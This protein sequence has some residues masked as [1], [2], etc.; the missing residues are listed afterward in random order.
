MET[1]QTQ[2][3]YEAFTQRLEPYAPKRKLKYLSGKFGSYIVRNVTG[4][5]I[6]GR[7]YYQD[8]QFQ[9]LYEESVNI[10]QEKASHLAKVQE[11]GITI[12]PTYFVAGTDSFNYLTLY[13]LSKEIQGSN[14]DTIR[15]LKTYNEDNLANT[16][17]N[18]IINLCA[19]YEQQFSSDDFVMDDV[20]GLHQYKIINTDSNPE[21]ILID[22][23]I[24]ISLPG[25]GLATQTINTLEKSMQNLAQKFSQ[26]EGQLHPSYQSISILKKQIQPTYS[27]IS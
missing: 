24:N 19:Y 14:L 18:F 9:K 10:G 13:S 26:Y 17:N 23:D 3:D 16:Y 25:P 20:A 6:Y 12:A 4:C 21:I 1:L 8:D 7:D 22:T 27:S 5:G 11:H 2:D 15:H